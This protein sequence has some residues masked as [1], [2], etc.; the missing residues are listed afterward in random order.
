MSR[1]LP[2]AW[3]LTCPRPTHLGGA[4]HREGHPCRRANSRQPLRDVPKVA[5]RLD[6]AVP[7]PSRANGSSR[8][9]ATRMVPGTGR[10]IPVAVPTLASRR[11]MS[12][13]LPGAWILPFRAPATRMVP[14]AP[15]PPGWCLAPGGTSLQRYQLSSAVGGCPEGCLAPGSCRSRAL[16][17]SVVPGT[18][19]DIPAAVPT[20]A[21]RRGMSRRLPGAWIFRISPRDAAVRHQS[22]SGR[23]P[24][25]A[26]DVSSARFRAPVVGDARAVMAPPADRSPHATFKPRVVVSSASRQRPR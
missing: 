4:W 16:P 9:P 1:R 15:R 25:A 7:R 21:S 26:T 18:G 24:H 3:I 5:W 13:R 2:G 22:S 8:A 11:G 10:D 6:L 19:R 14:P 20:L 12:R 23:D 17:T